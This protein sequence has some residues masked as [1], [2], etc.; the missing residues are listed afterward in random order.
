MPTAAPHRQQSTL[1]SASSGNRTVR[2]QSHSQIISR[3]SSPA[4]PSSLYN[5]EQQPSWGD[6]DAGP[7]DY[8]RRNTPSP[9]SLVELAPVNWR[10]LSDVPFD[11]DNIENGPDDHF[12]PSHNIHSPEQQI[13]NDT[14]TAK[15]TD[16]EE[17]EARL[18]QV[19]DVEA[20]Q[21][22]SPHLSDITPDWKGEGY[23]KTYQ[24]IMEASDNGV[25]AGSIGDEE[26]GRLNSPY[27]DDLS[28]RTPSVK[29]NHMKSAQT[30]PA[31][32]SP[33]KRASFIR[34]FDNKEVF[35]NM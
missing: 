31:T 34:K 4:S 26:F 30:T 22:V 29:S 14:S 24:D 18:Q 32:P 35:A 28:E 11:A 17:Y 6:N 13:E 2:A 16:E 8:W 10:K 15:E 12:W 21:P 3:H 1:S 9:Q 19:L 5:D 27:T 7:S 23:R 25:H 20:A 33:S